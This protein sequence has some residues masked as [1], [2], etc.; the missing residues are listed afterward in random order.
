M[1]IIL[2]EITEAA[3]ILKLVATMTTIMERYIFQKCSHQQID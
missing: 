1:K 3:N 2:S